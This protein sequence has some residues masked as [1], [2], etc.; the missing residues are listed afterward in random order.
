MKLKDKVAIITGGTSGMGEGIAHLFAREGASVVV[1]GRNEKRGNDI[2]ASIREEGGKALFVRADV[3]SAEEVENLVNAAVNEYGRVDILVPNAGLLGIGSVTEVS[4]ETWH[5]TISSNLDGVFYLCRYG[6]P[7]LIKQKGGVIVITASIAAY[8]GFP[9]HP[10]YCASKGALVALCR[11]LAIDY[12]QNNIRTN[13]ICPGPVDT[14]L[15]WDSA[16][17]FENP[18]SVVQEVGRNNLIGRLGTSE[19]VAQ[20]ALF[21]AGNDSSWITGTAITLDGGIMTGGC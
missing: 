1:S 5:H 13:C 15:L 17:A 7:E 12:A 19:D 8:K 6:I 18:E 2:A 4:L 16:K 21:L 3:T 9:N 11:N 20:T 14:P 10:A